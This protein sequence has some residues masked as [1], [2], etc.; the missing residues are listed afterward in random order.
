MNGFGFGQRN[1]RRADEERTSGVEG[2]ALALALGCRMAAVRQR[3]MA[4]TARRCAAP[5]AG[6]PRRKS[7]R[8]RR[9]TSMT[10]AAMRRVAW[11]IV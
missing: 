8:R 2:D 3:V 1:D 10:A 5:N 9:S 6:F 7:G 4:Q 11:Q